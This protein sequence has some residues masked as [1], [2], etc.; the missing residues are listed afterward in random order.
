MEINSLPGILLGSSF[1]IETT[2]SH[3]QGSEI[4]F[5]VSVQAD[6][7]H[8]KNDRNQNL[9][10]IWGAVTIVSSGVGPPRT[11]MQL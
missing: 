5:S 7:I 11:V 8:V 9:D 10:G 1:Y 6:S 2:K 4:E 3:I